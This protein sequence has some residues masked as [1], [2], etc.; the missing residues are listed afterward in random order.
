MKN[1]GFK[2]INVASRK[3]TS[4]SATKEV[5]ENQRTLS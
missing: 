1:P 5:T 3:L 2:I 4:R